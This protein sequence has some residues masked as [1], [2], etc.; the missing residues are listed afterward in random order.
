MEMSPCWEAGSVSA[1]K[2]NRNILRVLKFH[3][4]VRNIPSL[5]P[6]L[7]H[8]IP[9]HMFEPIRPILILTVYLSAMFFFSS[10]RLL[11]SLLQ[12]LCFFLLLYRAY[13]VPRASHCALCDYPK[14]M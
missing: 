11:L 1:K 8:M 12:K 10:G 4:R 7:S 14:D 9:V 5:V 3:Y 6:I 13:Y 2:T